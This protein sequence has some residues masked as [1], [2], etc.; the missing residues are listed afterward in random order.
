MNECPSAPPGPLPHCGHPPVSAV[1]RRSPEDFLVEE[2]P[3]TEPDGGGEHLWL[4]IEK[5]SENTDDLARRLARCAG[6]RPAAI[7]YAG[8]KDKHALTR[9]W[10]SVHLPGRD[11]PDAESFER[12]A[13]NVL[14]SARHSRKLKVGALRG[15]R[16]RLRLRDVDGDRDAL[17]ARLEEIATGGVPNYFGEQRF[18]RQAGNLARARAMFAGQR[19]RD[20]NRRGLYLSAARSA[21][22]NAILAERVTLGNWNRLLPGEVVQLDGSRSFFTAAPDDIALA[23][24]LA[25]WDIHPSG[26]LWGSGAPPTIGEAAALERA[27]ADRFADI[28]SGLEAAGLRQERRPLR[29]RPDQLGWAWEDERQSLILEFSLPA[30]TFATTVLREI[31]D[32]VD[33]G[34]HPEGE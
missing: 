16:F 32:Y 28:A 10:F 33:A 13:L 6:V 3:L 29:L 11:D 19:E 18:G 2:L 27:V 30:G 7:G 5:R 17:A 1:I 9:Q 4:L 15:N 14:R 20:R 8:R 22:F 23:D 34:G 25:R 24:R 21:L 31:A 12:D 26:A